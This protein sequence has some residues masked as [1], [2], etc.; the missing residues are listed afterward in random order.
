[1]KNLMTIDV[2]D[3]FQV[4]AFSETVKRDDWN[5]FELRVEQNTNR[6]LSLLDEHRTKAT[7]FVLGWVAERVPDLVR[8]IV[9][10]GH[11]LASHG[12]WHQHIS[13]QDPE[14]FRQDVRRA[15]Q[16]LEDISGE[17]V[18]GY[19]AP[20]YSIT[21]RNLWALNIL[22][23]EGYRYDSSIFPV[24]HDFYGI[25]T[26]PREPFRIGLTTSLA[27]RLE[28]FRIEPISGAPMLPPGEEAPTILEI[29][30]S[31]VR[32]PGVNLPIAGGGYFRI[33]PYSLVKW[34]LRRINREGKPFIFYLHPW[35]VDPGQ[36]RIQDIPRRSRFRHYTNLKQTESRFRRL[37]N[38]FAFDKVV[39]VYPLS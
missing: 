7:F 28:D 2:E 19:R 38:D 14:T 35:E 23:E 16:I 33:F 11:E 9:R 4:H 37:L 1:M 32:L 36:P 31:T 39:G 10:E 30:I 26:A 18:Y 12:T 21:N 17:P 25:P 15:R 8:T 27:T 5:G 24:R 29:P 3:Y 20:T 13:R 6:L 34:G 22:H